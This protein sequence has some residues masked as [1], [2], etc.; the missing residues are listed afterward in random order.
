MQPTVII[1]DGMKRCS[2][3]NLDLTDEDYRFINKHLHR[4]ANKINPYIYSD[5]SRGRPTNKERKELLKKM[6]EE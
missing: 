4:C 3:C 1:K 2:K 5:R 6:E